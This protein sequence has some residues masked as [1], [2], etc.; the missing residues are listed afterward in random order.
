[1]RNSNQQHRISE[2]KVELKVG[3]SPVE[4]NGFV[5][6]LFQEVLVGLVRSL[7]TEDPSKR[8]E[9]LIDAEPRDVR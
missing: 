2:R 5:Q 4:L 1:M 7:G 8:I 3:G 9:V 6:D